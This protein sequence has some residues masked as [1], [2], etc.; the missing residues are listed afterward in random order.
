MEWNA[1]LTIEKSQAIKCPSIALQLAGAKKVQQILA[2]SNELERF[3]K[4]EAVIAELRS[5]FA[6][7]YP[8]NEDTIT[9]IKANPNKYVLKPQ[10]EGGGNNIYRQDILPFLDQLSVEARQGYILMDLIQPP[11]E[12]LGNYV[13]AAGTAKL[14][15]VEDIVSELGIYGITL[16]DQRNGNCTVN[17]IGGHLLRTKGRD[18]SEGGVATG[19]SVLDSPY[20]GQMKKD[21]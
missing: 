19:Y 18:V 13:V 11:T 9:M 2:N 10:R 7:L 5:T 12:K 1:R 6:G 14:S 3:I 16:F 4:S 17:S 15:K 8:M 21:Q 20:L